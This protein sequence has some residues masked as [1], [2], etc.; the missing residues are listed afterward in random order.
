MYFWEEDAVIKNNIQAEVKKM[1]EIAKM[2]SCG[3]MTTPAL[4]VIK[5]L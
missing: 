3:V 2:M 1:E 4:V 5:K